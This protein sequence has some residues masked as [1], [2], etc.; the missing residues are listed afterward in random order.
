MT[1]TEKSILIR[2]DGV[3]KLHLPTPSLKMIII[4]K[5]KKS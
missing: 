4:I 2:G 5:N 3:G 1:I